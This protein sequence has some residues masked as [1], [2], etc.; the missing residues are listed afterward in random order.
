MRVCFLVVTLFVSI[1]TFAQQKVFLN[2]CNDLDSLSKYYFEKGDSYFL[3][4]DAYKDGYIKDGMNY[5]IKYANNLLTLNHVPFPSQ[6]MFQEIKK[7]KTMAHR[8]NATLQSI[9]ISP[10]NDATKRIYVFESRK[11][12]VSS[13]DSTNKS[14]K[15]YKALIEKEKELVRLLVA[16]KIIDKPKDLHISYNQKTILINGKKLSLQ[17]TKRYLPVFVIINHLAP[18][19]NEN[20]FAGFDIDKRIV[21]ELMPHPPE[22]S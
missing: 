7:L 2:N 20:E 10:E 18:P 5:D 12:E 17:Q 15:D 3:V 16:E 4:I 11:T 9:D 6:F 1:T 14:Y 19:E 22:K 13:F 8:F 21:E